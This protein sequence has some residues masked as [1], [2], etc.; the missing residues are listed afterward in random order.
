M[1]SSDRKRYRPG[2]QHRSREAKVGIRRERRL[3]YAGPRGAAF[4]I[5][6]AVTAVSILAACSAALPG[7][8]ASP[9]PRTSGTGRV[10]SPQPGGLAWLLTRSA[11]SQLLADPA[12]GDELRSSQVYEILQPGQRPLAGVTAKPVV[13]FASATAL[14]DAVTGGQLPDGTYGVLYDPEA[15]SLTPVT[16]QRDPVG[17]A[18]R[19]AAVA[20]AHGLRLI[21][22]PALNLTTVLNPGRQEPRWRQFLS[23]N[24]AG[25]LAGVADFLE[26]QAQSLERDTATYASFVQ[27]ATS[28]ASAANPRIIMLAGLSTN[29]PGAPVDSQSLVTAIRATRSM[30]D[31]YWLNIPGQGARCPTCNSP[32]LDIAIQTLRNLS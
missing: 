17:A 6:I 23:L 25:R 11:L 31:G 10:S 1:S 7:S 9:N 32:R 19:A 20:H 22:T 2:R 26:L 13:T 8:P 29:P 27:G 14:E 5:A 4:A 12:A 18:T 3:A 30:V 16:E 24:L 28:Q 21:V 15:W